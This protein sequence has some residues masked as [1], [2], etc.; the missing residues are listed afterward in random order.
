VRVGYSLSQRAFAA[1]RNA[2]WNSDAKDGMR[3]P[4]RQ[5][6]CESSAMP[7]LKRTQI[8]THTYTKSQDAHKHTQ[9]QVL[10]AC[11]GARAYKAIPKFQPP[12]KPSAHPKTKKSQPTKF[13]AKWEC[14]RRM[15]LSNRLLPWKFHR[16]TGLV[17]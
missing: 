12:E 8:L 13:T 14:C 16:I 9:G 17:G 5:P 2:K 10:C 7:C 15:L 6:H 1:R 11:L 4:F 3:K